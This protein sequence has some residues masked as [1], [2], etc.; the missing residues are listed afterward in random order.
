MGTRGGGKEKE[1]K[2]RKEKNHDLPDIHTKQQKY[3]AH[4]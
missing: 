1:K 2:K 3:A 4:T